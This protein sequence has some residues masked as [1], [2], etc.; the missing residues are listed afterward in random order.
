MK[1]PEYN[2]G[3]IMFEVIRTAL[4]AIAALSLYSLYVTL[5]FRSGDYSFY[6]AYAT[7]PEQI[8]STLAGVAVVVGGSAAAAYILSYLEK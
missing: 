5:A 8:E 3:R 1:L 2:L 7:V 4:F 6:A